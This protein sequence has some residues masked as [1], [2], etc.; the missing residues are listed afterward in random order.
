MN[1]YICNNVY[2]LNALVV[3]G[4][5]VHVF[6]MPMPSGHSL[7]AYLKSRYGIEII[8]FMRHKTYQYLV[9]NSRTLSFVDSRNSE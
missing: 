9:S 6:L 1:I 3:V 4:F 8:H 2:Q 7:I 5:A